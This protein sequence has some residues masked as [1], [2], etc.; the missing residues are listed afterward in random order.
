[1]PPSRTSK[2][3]PSSSLPSLSRRGQHPSR[4]PPTL[5]IPLPVLAI[6]A[7]GTTMASPA[8]GPP[9]VSPPSIVLPPLVLNT[10]PTSPHFP[11][12]CLRRPYFRALHLES[13]PHTQLVRA[14]VDARPT[15]RVI[16]TSAPPRPATSQTAPHLHQHPVTPHIAQH[17][18]PLPSH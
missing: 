17:P 6:A 11:H 5:P 1:M 18:Q 10:D 14:F 3:K 4:L 2:S 9:S 8:P 16:H 13:S 7:A 15:P 12:P